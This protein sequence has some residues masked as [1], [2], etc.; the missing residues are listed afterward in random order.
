M[1]KD[2]TQHILTQYDDSVDLYRGLADKARGL[3]AEILEGEGIQ[4]HSVT[5]RVKERESLRKKL[6][7]PDKDYTELDDITD[8]VGIRVITYFEDDVD[9]VARCLER[10]SR[11]IGITP[12]ISGKILARIA[13]AIRPC[14][15]LP[16]LVLT[17][18]YISNTLGSAN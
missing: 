1:A 12:S 8:I 6:D 3:V 16:S 5:S 15:T 18:Q 13:L 10:G 4:S 7:D 2:S 14:S 11:S 9:R 17:E